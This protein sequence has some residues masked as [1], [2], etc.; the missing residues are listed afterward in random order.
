MD[1]RT[2]DGIPIMAAKK[3]EQPVNKPPVTEP[4]PEPEPEPGFGQNDR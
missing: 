3:D 1:E 4:E 2:F